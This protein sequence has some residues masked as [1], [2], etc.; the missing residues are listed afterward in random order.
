MYSAVQTAVVTIIS[1]KPL[2]GLNFARYTG[3]YGSYMPSSPLGVYKPLI[4]H[5]I[6]CSHGNFFCVIF[7]DE[8]AEA[9]RIFTPLL[10]RIDAEK[11]Q[12]IKY[13]YGT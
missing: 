9:W 12:P 1:Y 8:L 11:P 4:L 13:T 2:S 10:H 3:Q 6:F 7:S 5:I